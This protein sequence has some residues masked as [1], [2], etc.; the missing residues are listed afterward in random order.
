MDIERLK[1]AAIAARKNAHVPYSGFAVGAAIL[2]KSGRIFQGCNVEN[3]SFRLTMC[4][5]EVALGTSVA[6]GDTELAA[7]VVVADSKH[8]AM[9]CGGCRQLLAEFAPDL[10][11]ISVTLDGRTETH[12]LSELLPRPKQ[13]ILEKVDGSKPRQI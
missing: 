10:Q 11:V 1:S 7:V 5:E 9:P 6:N 12:S 13:G 4:A 8:P 2:T 3:I